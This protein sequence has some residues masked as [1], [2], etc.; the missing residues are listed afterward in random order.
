M[1]PTPVGFAVAGGR[2][3]RMGR[4]KAEL[5]WGDT[6]L[7]DHA[8]ARLRSFCPRVRVLCGPEP[9]YLDRGVPI[10]IDARQ[11]T[12]PLAGLEA[13]LGSLADG[14]VAVLLGVDLP[15]VPA[16][17]LEWLVGRSGRA[18]AVVPESPRGP[19]PLAAVYGPA[20]LPAITA[21]LAGGDRRMT[22]FWPD[23]AVDRVPGP[24]LKP[25]GDPARLFVNLNTPADYES[26]AKIEGWGV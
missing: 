13:A 10:L 19:E 21:R 25:F 9:R 3:S 23:V 5:R 20:C 18:A 4:D 6:T 22:S 15:F 12:G 14:E 7:L 1:R 11:D 8:L 17:L 26:V 16:P 24:D 2:S